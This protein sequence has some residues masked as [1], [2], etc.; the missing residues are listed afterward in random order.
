MHR[1]AAGQHPFRG[2]SS[3]LEPEKA[4]CPD[5]ADTIPKSMRV[6]LNLKRRPA[7]T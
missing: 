4:S 7:P 2:A 5:A 3:V 1:Y 6:Y